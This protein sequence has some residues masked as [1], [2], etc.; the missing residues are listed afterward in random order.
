M[1]LEKERMWVIYNNF[2]FFFFK[3]MDNEVIRE[4]ILKKIAFFLKFLKFSKKYHIHE[5][6]WK[7]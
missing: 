7:F 6:S 2:K 4:I 5:Y 1:S 3:W